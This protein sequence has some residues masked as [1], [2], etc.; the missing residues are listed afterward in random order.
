MIAPNTNYIIKTK[1]Q[2][3]LNEQT[4]MTAAR[5]THYLIANVLYTE[6]LHV[7]DVQFVIIIF[8]T[9]FPTVLIAQFS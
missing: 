5:L 7:L 8:L 9:G 2:K 3:N 6:I 4:K 1:K